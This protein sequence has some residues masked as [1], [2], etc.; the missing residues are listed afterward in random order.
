MFLGSGS[1]LWAFINSVHLAAATDWRCFVFRHCSKHRVE[2]GAS[3]CIGI[4]NDVFEYWISY[5]IGAFMIYA[6]DLRAIWLLPVFGLIFL[7][8]RL[9]FVLEGKQNA[10]GFY[11]NGY[12]VYSIRFDKN[13]IR[14]VFL[15]IMILFSLRAPLFAEQLLTSHNFRDCGMPK[16]A[17][18]SSSELLLFYPP[19]S[20]WFLI[21][22][23][24][25]T[26]EH[27]SR[28]SSCCA[29]LP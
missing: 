8:D 15:V 28:F 3:D 17:C 22:F 23:V 14:F 1:Y 5:Y 10:C 13:C 26:F 12:R 21:T 9:S 29:F 19:S 2:G 20:P 4:G 24:E 11:S 18:C 27:L 7:L 6:L 25:K 16:P